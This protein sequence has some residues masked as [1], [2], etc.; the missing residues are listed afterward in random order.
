MIIQLYTRKKIRACLRYANILHSINTSK[1]NV[2]IFSF[3]PKYPMSSVK[4][5]QNKKMGFKHFPNKIYI[6]EKGEK[7]HDLLT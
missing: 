6:L 5:F 2:R 4:I 3:L 7:E 1:I